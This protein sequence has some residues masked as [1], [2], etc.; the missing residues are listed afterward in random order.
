M[1]TCISGD[2]SNVICN[3]ICNI[4]CNVI[5][6]VILTTRDVIFNVICRTARRYFYIVDNLAGRINRC[7]LKIASPNKI[8]SSDLLGAVVRGE[9][10]RDF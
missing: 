10:P 9:G 4:I 2:S 1:L 6:N 7:A 5:C 3:V 8:V